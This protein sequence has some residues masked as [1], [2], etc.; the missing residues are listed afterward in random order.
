M[1]PMSA[2]NVAMV[3]QGYARF[4]AGE[5]LRADEATPD[6]VWDMSSFSGWIEQRVYAGTDGMAAFLAEWTSVWDDWRLDVQALHDGGD[7]VV[8][9]IRQHG[10]SKLTGMPLDMPFAQV[11]T[12]RDGLRSRME[13]Y[14][15]VSEAM[16][17]AGLA[18][19]DEG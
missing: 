11:W 8:A 19:A 5:A 18:P 17:A 7:M 15:D 13:M 12:F 10:N 14:S 1:G 16:R 2:E 4:A 6:F 3:R 9:I